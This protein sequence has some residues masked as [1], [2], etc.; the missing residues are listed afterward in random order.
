MCGWQQRVLE[1]FLTSVAVIIFRVKEK[2]DSWNIFQ[3][4]INVIPVE[5]PFQYQDQQNKYAAFFSGRKTMAW[6]VA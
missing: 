6:M 5:N 3:F 4:N 2:N 1:S